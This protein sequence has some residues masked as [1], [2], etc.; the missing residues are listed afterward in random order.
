MKKNMDQKIEQEFE[1]STTPISTVSES[2]IDYLL[3][4]FALFLVGCALTLRYIP[5]HIISMENYWK[6]YSDLCCSSFYGNLT[7]CAYSS[8]EC[9]EKLINWFRFN[10]IDDRTI[11]SCCF[12]YSPYNETPQS[13]CFSECFNI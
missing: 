1:E 9:K 13:Y 5:I 2:K 12:W 10:N 6:A 11:K 4:G 7:K 3:I 8:L